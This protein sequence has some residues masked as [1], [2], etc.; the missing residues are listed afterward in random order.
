MAEFISSFG[1]IRGKFGN[2]ISYVG[3]NGKNY[4]KGASLSRKSGTEAQKRQA[5]AF[6]A[7]VKGKIWMKR[8][9][10]LGFPGNI[11]P[12]GFNG[13]TSVNVMTA[14]TVEK[15]D[16]TKPVDRHK[17]TVQ[18]F[19]GTIDYAKLRVAA[20]SL[21][22][23]VVVCEVDAE[24]RKVHFTH[25]K[26][27][28]EAIDCFGDDEIYGVLLYAPNYFCK[29]VKLGTRGE[30]MDESMSFPKEVEAEGMAIYVFAR[31]ADGKDTSDSVCLQDGVY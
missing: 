30:N 9:I 1:K 14:V 8:V 21:V 5:A 28:V 10:R 3:A 6:S 11:Y 31:A 4:C 29:V 12:K 17:K 18:E 7:V 2:V 22:P 27:V 15:I 23:P 19:R 20:G 26:V 24:D 13:F 16:S 25:Q